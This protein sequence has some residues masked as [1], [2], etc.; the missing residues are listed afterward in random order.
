MAGPVCIELCAGGGGQAL[1]LERAGFEHVSLFDVDQASCATLRQ[2][3][4]S[5]NVWQADIKDL[6][7]SRYRGIDLLAGGLPCPP[8]SVAGKQ[9]GY[10]DERDLFPAAIRLIAE[11]R[12]RA[13]M[14]ENVRGLLDSRFAHYRE[15]ILLRLKSLGYRADWQ[16]LD[17]ADFGVSQF[18]KRAILV[19]IDAKLGDRFIWPSPQ[20]RRP[21]TVGAKLYDQIASRGWSRAL[22]WRLQANGLAPTIVGGSAKH[23]GPDLGP[24]RARKAWAALGVDGRGVADDP[25]ELDSP[26]MPRLTVP[27]IGRL[28]G[29][30]DSWHFTGKKTSAYRQVG[31][32]FPPPVAKAVA[33]QIIA[34]LES[35]KLFHVQS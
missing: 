7:G 15:S 20:N 26:L 14:I 28:Q 17:A 29:F 33:V 30:P 5:W 11:A 12:P 6:D 21:V 24:V 9:L 22:D 34:A 2:N 16:L 25:P 18:R 32:A 3:R 23:G 4:V 27:M 1:G 19:A 10:A 8:F 13:V 31:N 35:F